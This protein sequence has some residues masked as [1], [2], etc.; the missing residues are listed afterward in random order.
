MQI[1]TVCSGDVSH[2]GAAIFDD[3]FNNHFFVSKY[4]QMSPIAE[5]GRIRRDIINVIMHNLASR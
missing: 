4:Q 1:S 5:N 2:V 3:K